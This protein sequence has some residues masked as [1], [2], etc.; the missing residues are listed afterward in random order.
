MTHF[1]VTTS[2]PEVQEWFDQGHTLLHGFWPFEAERSFRWCIKLDPNCAMERT[3][4]SHA[5]AKWM[6]SVQKSSCR[7][8]FQRKELVT[9]RERA[10]IELWVAK[11]KVN[12]AKQAAKKAE[13]D[14]RATSPALEKARKDYVIR[15]DKLLM[16]YPEDIEGRALYW[17]EL[18]RT[19]NDKAQEEFNTHRFGMECVLQEV[20][21]RIPG[22]SARS[23][24]VSTTGIAGK[25]NTPSIVALS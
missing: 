7:K 23:T 11:S 24:I 6:T 3:G 20:L 14:D 5:V 25:A 2:H 13:S 15:F 9:E 4:G 17:L 8:R 12:K 21:R 19:L 18:P 1:P 16:N 10:Y 22:M